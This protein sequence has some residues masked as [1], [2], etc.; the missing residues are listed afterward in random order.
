MPVG[1]SLVKIR[2]FVTKPD[3]LNF[4]TPFESVFEFFLADVV[5]GGRPVKDK[6]LFLSYG[7][8]E[9]VK[10]FVSRLKQ[11]LE[12]RGFTVWLDMEDIPAGNSGIF[13]RKNVWGTNQNFLKFRRGI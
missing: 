1:F 3:T 4:F 8:E 10:S 7:H 5:D 2:A 11:D 13:F 9:E 6:Q 12:R